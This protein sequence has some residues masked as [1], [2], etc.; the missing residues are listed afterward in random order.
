MWAQRHSLEKRR[1]E[2]GN[3]L[4]WA[5]WSKE[6]AAARSMNSRRR[7]VLVSGGL[8]AL[9]SE[10]C[11]MVLSRGDE[12]I[13]LDSLSAASEVD[14]VNGW[15]LAEKR[16]SLDR[17][18]AMSRLFRFVSEDAKSTMTEAS[19][20]DVV[21]CG[22]VKDAA[23]VLIESGALRAVVAS[24]A[25]VYD[26]STGGA[27]RGGRSERT[28]KRPLLAESDAPHDEDDDVAE[29]ATGAAR[30][31]ERAAAEACRAR[32]DLG[33]VVLRYFGV[34]GG[35]ASGWGR[36]VGSEFPLGVR[37]VGAYGASDFCGLGDAAD[38]A[39][40][41]LDWCALARP[42]CVAMNVGT[43]KPHPPALARAV[44]LK[45]LAAVGCPAPR[46][47]AGPPSPAFGAADVSKLRAA[48][49][50]APSSSLEAALARELA[51]AVTRESRPGGPW[52]VESLEDQETR[53]LVREALTVHSA[54]DEHS[55]LEHSDLDRPGPELPATSL[56]A[57]DLASCTPT[58]LLQV[59]RSCS[60]R[61]DAHKLH[62]FFQ[63]NQRTINT[64][65]TDKSYDA[66]TKSNLAAV[67]A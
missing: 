48:L 8:G 1:G 27:R 21:V 45:T 13:C 30:R 63:L 4:E 11:E 49:G 46:A 9:G 28:H 24:S 23:D 19:P 60:P 62:R 50:W 2:C 29:T 40:R 51:R 65:N 17:L 57:L 3:W 66:T 43:G 59:S 18:S 33:V 56:A 42:S 20:T 67:F 35:T 25:A 15:S 22:F 38:A 44:A 12:V 7:R 34:F 16:G 26:T 53:R 52:I 36:L 14:V 31:L 37:K 54:N 47:N 10:V 5:A 64:I 6:S 41:A 55:T 39:L 32:S 58:I 61:K